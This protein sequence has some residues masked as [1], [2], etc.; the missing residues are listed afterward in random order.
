[1]TD[2]LRTETTLINATWEP[3]AAGASARELLLKISPA[4]STTE[5]M[6]SKKKVRSLRLR[7]LLFLNIIFM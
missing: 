5:L 2:V 1:L 6:L 3:T 7:M 4:P